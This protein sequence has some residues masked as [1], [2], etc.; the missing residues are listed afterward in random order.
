VKL[1]ALGVRHSAKAVLRA[2]F[3]ARLEFYGLEHLGRL[4]RSIR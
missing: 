1:S 3:D 4:F 2:V